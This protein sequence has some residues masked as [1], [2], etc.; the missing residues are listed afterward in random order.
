MGTTIKEL[1]ELTAELSGFEG[2]INW[3]TSMPD[4][5]MRKVLDVSHMAAALD[6]TAPTALCEGLAETIR[7][8]RASRPGGQA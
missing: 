1:A 4:G 6:W 8:Y 3:N 7:W 5:A 2:T